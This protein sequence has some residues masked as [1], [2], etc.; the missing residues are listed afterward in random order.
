LIEDRRLQV[1]AQVSER[2]NCVEL[3]TSRDTSDTLMRRLVQRRESF[4]R[5]SRG[6]PWPVPQGS[7]GTQPRR[8][9]ILGRARRTRR[10]RV[11]RTRWVAV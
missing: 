11:A 1:G 7:R 9:D 5:G 3:A 10:K 8:G 2:R 4:A 6:T